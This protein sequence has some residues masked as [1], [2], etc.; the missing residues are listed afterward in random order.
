M[1]SFVPS[2]EEVSPSWLGSVLTEPSP[3]SSIDNFEFKRVGEAY[4]FASRIF[5]FSWQEHRQAKSVIIKFWKLNTTA[6]ANELR[7]YQTFK[8]LGV[9]T[10]AFLYGAHDSEKAI[11]ILEDL[12][13]AE[14]GDVLKPLSL[15][16]AKTVARSLAVLH[17]EWV[18]HPQLYQD[19]IIDLSSWN[20][21]ATWIKERR[22]EFLERFPNHLSQQALSLL[23]NL[24]IA[25]PITSK[26][27]ASAPDTLLHGDFHL[28]NLLFEKNTPI[29]LD[30][31]RPAR[32]AAS[33][34][35]VHLLFMMTSTTYFDDILKTYLRVY[36]NRASLNYQECLSHLGGSLLHLFTQ[37]TCGVARWKPS[38]ARAKDILKDGISRVNHMVAFWHKRDP[39]FF[40]FLS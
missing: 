6:D 32:G 15:T 29:F 11:L 7:F 37:S 25:L 23:N 39:T 16:E 4:G 2:L 22:S 30:W 19:W 28:D 38:L 1:H 27:L 18:E 12:G 9:R 20:P 14:Q 17:S 26:R 35:L 40:D 33:Y 24:E 5:R 31:S 13:F 34:N 10:P 3:P 21:D 8:A 36:Q